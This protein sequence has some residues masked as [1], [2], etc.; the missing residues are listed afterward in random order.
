MKAKNKQAVRLK[1]LATEYAKAYASM[2]WIGNTHPDSHDEIREDYKKAR[3]KLHQAIEE[4]CPPPF[5]GD[6]YE[7]VC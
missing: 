3:N 1:R 6:H 5:E 7:R 2:T 4:A